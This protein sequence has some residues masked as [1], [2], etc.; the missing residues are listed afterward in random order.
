VLERRRRRTRPLA[1]GSR[2]ANAPVSP[3]K[4]GFF[5]AAQT[6]RTF[7]TGSSVTTMAAWPK[8]ATTNAARVALGGRRTSG[9]RSRT[10]G[11]NASKGSAS[12]FVAALAA[13]RR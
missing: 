7:V 1:D 11:C 3:E 8:R 9:T 12:S 10:W 2:R 4:C 5:C 13:N 6:Q